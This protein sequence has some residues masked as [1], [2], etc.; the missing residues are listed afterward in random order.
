MKEL[1]NFTMARV[2]IWRA[3]NSLPTRELLDFQL[4]HARARDAVHFALDSA[5]I[6]SEAEARGWETVIVHSAARDR[7]EYLRRPDLGRRLSSESRAKLE[8]LSGG[9]DAVFAIADGL[10]ALAVHRHAVQ[11][12]R[13]VRERVSGRIAPVVIAEQGRVALSD[14][15][16]AALNA[17]LAVML[18]GERPGLSSPDSLGAY[19]TWS[20]R[21]G[22][23]DAERNCIS[24][25]RPEGMSTA[26]AAELLVMLINA[27]RA[28]QISG[29]TLSSE[30]ASRGMIGT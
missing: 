15:I 25:I 1:R 21:P 14:D 4:A 5:A 28:R 20:P 18:I 17:S 11:L 26:A 9:F 29:V 8:K 30:I 10:S 13:H 12:L 23:A 27:A 19:L 2:G 22:R 6:Q 7:S 16:G 3:G 24:N